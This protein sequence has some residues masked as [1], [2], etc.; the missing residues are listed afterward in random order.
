M[1]LEDDISKCI[2]VLEKG[3][4]ILYPT[5]TIWGLGCNALNNTAVKKIFKIKRRPPK[6][7]MILLVDSVEMVR[8]YVASANEIL[9]NYLIEQKVPTTGIFT[10]AKNLPSTLIHEDGTIAMRITHDPFC[11][12]LIEL[13]G[14]PIVSTSVNF[15]GNPPAAQFSEI[16]PLIKNAVDYI[17]HHRRDEYKKAMPSRLVKLDKNNELNFL[18]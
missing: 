8:K 4:L 9:I 6:K 15:S 3:G 16:D 17:V 13:F 12:K 11:K 7:S 18:R 2:E 14:K 1:K 10:D 5:D